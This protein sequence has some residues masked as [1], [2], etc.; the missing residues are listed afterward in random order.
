[1]QTDCLVA[2][3]AE[4]EAQSKE[5]LVEC[6]HHEGVHYVLS[7]CRGQQARGVLPCVECTAPDRTITL[8]EVLLDES[9]G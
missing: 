6:P 8:T 9:D 4:R 2:H 1:M 7:Y 3:S 5:R